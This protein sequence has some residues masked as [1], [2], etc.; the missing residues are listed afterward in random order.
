MTAREPSPGYD[1]YLELLK[2][3]LTRSLFGE[4]HTPVVL[5]RGTWRHALFSPAQR[6]FA[7]GNIELVRNVPLN[8]DARAEGR[9]LPAHAE[10]MIGLRRLENIHDC[11]SDV[12]RTGVPGDLV[13]TG[14]WRGGAT[15]FMRAILKAYGDTERKVWVADSFEGLPR[16]DMKRW[17]QD[18]GDK[19]WAIDHLAV[20]LD[21]VRGNFA[22][23]G[24]LDDQVKFLPGFFADTLPSAPIEQIAVLRL[25]ADMYGSTM[26]ALDALYPKLSPGGYT[27]VDD[28]WF[29]ESCRQAVTDYR[30]RYGINDPIKRID[31]TGVWWQKPRQ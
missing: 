20:S 18:A 2:G 6:L 31:W 9:D 4:E 12:L 23:Y 25:D 26:E 8:P 1:A 13:E 22:R 30:A 28:Y 19:L 7:I 5:H 27:I 3:C 16:P 11:V 17:P 10:T 24:L 14:V 15:I 29:L 21:D